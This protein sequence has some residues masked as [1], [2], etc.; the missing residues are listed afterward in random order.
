MRDHLA[1]EVDS[2]CRVSSPIDRDNDP[3]PDAEVLLGPGKSR[4]DRVDHVGVVEAPV[5]EVLRVDVVLAIAQI[6]VG[7]GFGDTGIGD[8]LEVF[9]IAQHIMRETE[10]DQKVDQVSEVEQLV[11]VGGRQLDSVLGCQFD[12]QFGAHRRREVA[13]QLGLGQQAQIVGVRDH[14]V[15]CPEARGGDRPGTCFTTSS[16]YGFPSADHH[17]WVVPP[18]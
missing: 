12:E 13:V 18:V 8:T 2:G 17:R 6:A 7:D 9:G 16:R 15:T 10:C 14:A 3:E 11:R 1:H 5:G 4:D